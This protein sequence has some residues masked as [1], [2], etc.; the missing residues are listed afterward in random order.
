MGESPNTI[1]PFKDDIYLRGMTHEQIINHIS[2][3]SKLIGISNLFS[4]AFPAVKLLIDEIKSNF[5]DIP[6]VLGGP[7]PTHLCD[8]TLKNTRTDYIITGE[9]EVPIIHLWNFILG[10]LLIDDVPSLA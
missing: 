4:F 10:N 1:T 2:N 6:V 7:H 9:G 3:K 5:P 8:F